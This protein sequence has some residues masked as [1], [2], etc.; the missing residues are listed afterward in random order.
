MCETKLRLKFQNNVIFLQQ[1]RRN[2]LLES[3]AEID[4]IETWVR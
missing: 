3:L 4:G 2:C 1:L